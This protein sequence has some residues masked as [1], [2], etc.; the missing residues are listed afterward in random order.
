MAERLFETLFIHAL[1][2]IS[3]GGLAAVIAK[4]TIGPEYMCKV[5]LYTG[6]AIFLLFC[7]LCPPWKQSEE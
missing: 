2:G 4:W 7:C 1:W 6:L 5:W 3:L